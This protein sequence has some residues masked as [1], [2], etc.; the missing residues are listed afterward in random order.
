MDHLHLRRAGP[1]DLPA[2]MTIE[3]ASFSLPWSEWSMLQELTRE[4]CIYLIAEI[5]G[6][7]VGYGGLWLGL[8]E[9]H[10]G[11]LAVSPEARGH[12]VAEA[13]M[14]ALIACA[15]ANDCDIVL[16]EYRVSNAPAEAL[17]AKLGFQRN[18]IRRQYYPDNK[19]DAVEAILP[20]VQGEQ[21]AARMLQWVTLW[22]QR[23]GQTFPW[24]EWSDDEA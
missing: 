9:G 1:R 13:V 8:D 14:L 16:L 7:A 21:F 11:T 2:I 19:E 5:E 12:G 23:R 4:D 6:I 22:E 10:V 17:Y 24:P 20:D 18:R 15:R 3:N